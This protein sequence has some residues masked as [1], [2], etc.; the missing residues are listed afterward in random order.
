M[1]FDSKLST[2]NDSQLLSTLDNL[3]RSETDATLQVIDF[4]MELE[5]RESYL[6]LG[7][8]S[9]FD[10]CTRKLRYSEPEANRRIK[11]A[12][13][14]A[15][16]PEVRKL[17]SEKA[18][19]LSTIALFYPLLSMETKAEVLCSV[20]GKSK[21]EV[22]DFVSLF[23]AT[24]KPKMKERI[25][26]VLCR[27]GKP[28][29]SRPSFSLELQPGAKV[30]KLVEPPAGKSEP[31]AEERFQ[32]SFSV[33]KEVMELIKKAQLLMSR[34]TG[35]PVSLE[36]A[37]IAGLKEYIHAH[38]PQQEP[39]ERSCK[40]SEQK[41]KLPSPGKVTYRGKS[42][43]LTRR[44]KAE[45]SKRDGL[46]CSFVGPDGTRCGNRVGLQF[47]HVKPFALGGETA[48]D[49]LRLLGARHNRYAAEDVFGREVMR[50]FGKRE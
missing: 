48:T 41:N 31:E 1:K 26:P 18:V 10:Y 44:V 9:L 38:D 7:Y 24:P 2:L 19:S 23:R 6:G 37:M 39:K 14:I 12:R 42:R 11:A 34:K 4:L 3:V 13:C 22:E 45:V 36:E 15:G 25:R 29:A 33:D 27:A 8:S 20:A 30:E 35:K 32:L 43:Y 16:F 5:R 50:K 49:N 40:S 28:S 17:L 46:C 47:D 21:R